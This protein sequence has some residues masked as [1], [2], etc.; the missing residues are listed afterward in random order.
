MDKGYVFAY[1]ELMNNPIFEDPWLLKIWLWCLFKACY[2]PQKVI[3]GNSVTNLERG[4]FLFGREKAAKE[5]SSD[6]Y[7]INSSTLYR[8]MKLLEK[9]G[10]I[11]LNAN[12]LGTVVTIVNYDNYQPFIADDEQQVNSERTASEHLIKNKKYKKNNPLLSPL[13]KGG[14]KKRNDSAT[15][16]LGLYEEMLNSDD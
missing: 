10:S 1:R 15:F 5:L 6:K 13:K 14:R 8:K 9:M 3:Q 7:K 11:S 4:E 16:D 12:S 2:M